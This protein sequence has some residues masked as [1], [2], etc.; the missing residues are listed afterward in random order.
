[1]TCAV[2]S[3][4]HGAKG[5]GAV[6]SA[7]IRQRLAAIMAADVAGYSRLMAQDEPATVVALDTAR[8]VFAAV[9][10]AH[11]GRV[12]DMA[13]DSVLAVFDTASGAVSAAVQVQQ[14][15]EAVAIGIREDRHMRF[16][17]GIHI[18]DVL[19]KTD[20][21]VYGDGVNIAS[22]LE[23]LA[24]PGAIAV[25]D[26]VRGAVRGRFP[27]SFE[28]AGEH[29][30]KNMARPVR[31]YRLSVSES[32][33]GYRN[34]R[35]HT[36]VG[37]G[38]EE[39]QRA[40]NPDVPSTALEHQLP[41]R[42]S[43]VVFPFVNTHGAPVHDYFT[44][45][46]TEDLT[47]QL[48]FIKGSYVIGAGTA[49]RY[50]DKAFSPEG[51]RRELGVHYAL[52]GRIERVERGVDVMAHL[53]D[54]TSG[55]KL[56]EDTIEVNADEVRNIRREM[57]L[58]MT[59]ALRLPLIHA[60]AQDSLKEQLA[61]PDVVDLVM[62]GRA[63]FHGRYTLEANRQALALFE[64]ALA[65]RPDDQPALV[66]CAYVLMDQAFAWLGRA[67][68]SSIRRADEL[69]KLAMP[70]NRSDAYAHY[71]LARVRHLQHRLEASVAENDMAIQLNPNL[72]E[73][74]AWAGW[75][76]V[77]RER[78]LEAMDPL[79]RV[80]RQSPKDRMR[81]TWFAWL[82][83]AYLFAD[84]HE[85]AVLWLERATAINPFHWSALAA[86]AAAYSNA[87]QEP[88]ANLAK[89]RFEEVHRGEDLDFR[90]HS[91]NPSFVAL[92]ENKLF[93][94]WRKLGIWS[95]PT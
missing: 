20:G 52:R 66:S 88:Q 29:Q 90:S 6:S 67:A 79:Q 77:Y 73:A 25:S 55:A 34:E 58:R 85:E 71:T 59:V 24:H 27:L 69:L 54:C 83:V 49:L 94:P 37:S 74:L 33:A 87:G 9:I 44:D 2:R 48:S 10:E 30:V 41:S 89:S 76:Y 15:L 56:W 60:A 80:I 23:G 82:G 7:N 1:M 14:T 17:I 19:E 3:R 95:P 62:Q 42:L 91:S 26:V 45:C 57:V 21:T 36:P 35:V 47:T 12:I 72:I 40:T 46:I 65:I 22:R 28:D 63:I 4:N 39:S 16:R 68:A 8:A 31:V 75:L 64:R 43:I 51:L 92:V 13:G 11:H 38:A 50:K 84:Q 81:W 53:V 61:E 86:L 32:P 93:K 70:L 5:F 18:G 78:P